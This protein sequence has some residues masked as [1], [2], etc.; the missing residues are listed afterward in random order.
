[1]SASSITALAPWFGS[2]RNLAPEIVRELRRHSCYWEPFCGSMAVL[3]A[4]PCG[5]PG[6]TGGRLKADVRAAA[7]RWYCENIQ[8]VENG[9]GE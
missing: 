1:V 3:L 8:N 7:G 4:K 5:G 6:D 2:K 9:G